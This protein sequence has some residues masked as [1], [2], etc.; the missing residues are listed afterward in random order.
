MNKM[1]IPIERQNY[2]RDQKEIL[3]LKNM[4]SELKIF[5]DKLN[6][7]FNKEKEEIGKLDGRAVEMS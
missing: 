5:S 4:I 2:K 6:S 7:R 3:D 1:R